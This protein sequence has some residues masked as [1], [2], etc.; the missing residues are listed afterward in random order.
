MTRR[1]SDKSRRTTAPLT[2]TARRGR[3]ADSIRIALLL[4]LVAWLP[5]ADTTNS[6]PRARRRS[7]PG[8]PSRGTRA[9][10]NRPSGSQTGT[11]R[12]RDAL[13]PA[14]IAQGCR[15]MAAESPTW[16]RPTI[17]TCYRA[18]SFVTSTVGD[19]AGSEQRSDANGRPTGHNSRPEERTRSLWS[20]SLLARGARWSAGASQV[21][22]ASRPPAMRSRTAVGMAEPDGLTAAISS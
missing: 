17:P 8:L 5:P 16:S 3:L 1:L 19:R 13:F 15:P 11:V 4:A 20:T 10:T 12:M 6:A 9:R 14:R 18:C 2:T 7:A 22:S 21:G